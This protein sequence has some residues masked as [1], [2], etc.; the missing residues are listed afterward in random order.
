MH[1]IALKTL[2]LQGSYR[3]TVSS[4]EFQC[5]RSQTSLASNTFDGFL[6]LDL[7]PAL[8]R[9]DVTHLLG[10]PCTEQHIWTPSFYEWERENLRGEL[11][12]HLPKRRG[13]VMAEL[14]QASPATASPGRSPKGQGKEKQRAENVGG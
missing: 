1:N 7:L 11:T 6:N 2:P 12:V 14:R 13:V 10:F 3:A 4:K 5:K 9:N 8:H